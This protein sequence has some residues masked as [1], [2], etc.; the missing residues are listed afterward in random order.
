MGGNNNYP[1]YYRQ[2]NTPLNNNPGSSYPQETYQNSNK[3]IWLLVIVFILAALIIFLVIFFVLSSSKTISEDDFSSGTTFNLKENKKIKFTFEEEKHTLE[4]DYVGTSSVNLIIRSN[5][6]T[7]NLEIGEEEKFDLDND[8]FFDIKIKLNEITNGIPK[9]YLKKIHESICTES[10]SCGNW[11]TCTLSGSQ[12]RT[13]IDSNSCGT[14]ENKPILGQACIYVEPCIGNWNCTN[15]STCFN[16]TQNRS[17]TDLNNCENIIDMP[18]INQSCTMCIGVSNFTS[19]SSAICCNGE[20]LLPSFNM[21]DGNT[22]QKYGCCGPD[23]CHIGNSSV[24]YLCSEKGTFFNATIPETTN[25]YSVVCYDTA[26]WEID[27]TDCTWC[28]GLG[29]PPIVLNTSKDGFSGLL[30]DRA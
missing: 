1:Q 28:E 16:N 4:V 25:N 21:Q 17:C 30:I 29:S 15:W 5:P 24:G 8:D 27:L 3:T 26:W 23:T 20:T 7:L 10:W 22:T 12:A 11:S 2:N 6:I 19:N 18:D 14:I 13:C 9:L